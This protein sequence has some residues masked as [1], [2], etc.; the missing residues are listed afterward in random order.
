MKVGGLVVAL[1]VRT[2]EEAVRLAEDLA[3]HVAGFSVGPA[4]LSGPGP[5]VIGALSSLAPV[6]ADAKLHDIPD[7]VAAAARRLGEFG[8]RWVSVHAAGGGAMVEAAVAGL[9]GAA[10]GGVLAVTVLTSLDAPGL[11]ASGLGEGA[12]RLVSRLTRVAAAAG[13]EGVLCPAKELPVAKDV[14]P[15]LLRVAAGIRGPED[16]PGGHHGATTAAEAVARGADLVVVG[17]PVV[18]ASDP[19]GAAAALASSMGCRR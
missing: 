16:D 19:V 1:D 9:G 8:A 5:G 2:A 11:R 12:G 14:A 15:D 10:D 3:T 4:L 18:A 17:R 7:V 13:A 6:L